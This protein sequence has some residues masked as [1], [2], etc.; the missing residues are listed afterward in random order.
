MRNKLYIFPKYSSKGPSS[1]YRIY[2]YLDF[3]RKEKYDMVL[4]PLFG[5]WYLDTIWQHKTKCRVAHKILWSYLKRLKLI[6]FLPS[7]S[8]VYIGSEL[9]PYIPFGLERI[10]IMKKIKYILE[11]DDAIFHY[12]DLSSSKLVLKIL[13]HKTPKV[14]SK[15]A[16]IITGSEYLTKYASK[17]NKNVVEIP[18]SIDA[19]KYK[20]VDVKKT[21][22]FIIGWIGS[23]SQ[24]KQ[25]L[26]ILPALIELSLKYKYKLHLIGFDAALEIYL[27]KVPYKLI[28]WDDATEIEEMSRF[29]VGIMPLEDTPFNR[30]KCAF[31]LVQYMSIGIPTISTPLLSNLNINKNSKNL[32]CE[33]QDEW[34]SAF[35]II[36]NN[37]NMY[38]IIGKKNKQ[39][40]LKNYSIQSNAKKYL[41]IFIDLLKKS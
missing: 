17:F 28:E 13:G 21:N 30:G 27:D 41:T 20:K 16:C 35:E 36:I 29:S 22:E 33:T 5:D 4:N 38:N 18:T 10:L 26:N 37:Q 15:A 6:L 39:I 40:A 1:R 24:S 8:V 11:F 7:K 3:Y 9:F 25:V 32:F 31:K 12:Y 19:E 23:S 2:N 14:I 34:F